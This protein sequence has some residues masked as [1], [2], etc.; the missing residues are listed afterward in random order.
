M[1]TYYVGPKLMPL[2][3]VASATTFREAVRLCWDLRTR[4]GLLKSKLAEEAGLYA[5]HVTDY[6]SKED[7]RRELPAKHIAAFEEACGNRLITQWL[8]MRASLTIL[9]TLMQP[10]QVAA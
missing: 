7:A 2:D 4:T 9:E 3:V 8:A 10:R 6:L 1:L 5:S